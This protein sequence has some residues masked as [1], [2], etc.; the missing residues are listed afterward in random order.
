MT[1]N[2]TNPTLSNPCSSYNHC[3]WTWWIIT[4]ASGVSGIEPDW[5]KVKHVYIFYDIEIK[6]WSLLAFAQNC[7]RKISKNLLIILLLTSSHIRISIIAYRVEDHTWSHIV[8]K[9]LYLN[10]WWIQRFK[11]AAQYPH[12]DWS[13]PN[14]A[15]Q[16]II[17]SHL[18]HTEHYWPSTFSATCDFW[19]S[20]KVNL[21]KILHQLCCQPLAGSLGWYI[22][23]RTI[24][25]NIGYINFYSRYKFLFKSWLI[26]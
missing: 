3:W 13:S 6:S 26:K 19:P 24:S 8:T 11:F 23:C 9:Q 5:D 20:L 2:W 7:P 18:E 17:A 12:I 16:F 14:V 21:V 4:S 1:H 22:C 25:K 10:T 15:I